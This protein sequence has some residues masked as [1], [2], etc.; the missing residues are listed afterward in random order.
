LGINALNKLIDVLRGENGCPWDKK[1]TPRS[2][3]VYL[4]E[5]IYELLEAIESG[6]TDDICE[7]LGDVLFHILFIAKL[8]QEMGS[9]NIEDA[10]SVNKEKM[11]RRHPHVFGDS[12]V[13]RPDDLRKQWH[14]IKMNEKTHSEN[15]SI[16]DSIP[17]GLPALRRAYRISE[18]AARVGFDWD[19]ISDVMQKVEEECSE[20]K[21][22]LN[23]SSE[24]QESLAIE[25]GDVIFTLVNVARFAR[26]HP[27]NA[28]TD[29][30]KKFENRFKYIEKVILKSGRK[31]ESVSQGEMNELWE[32]AKRKG[33][34]SAT[35]N[36]MGA[37]V[38]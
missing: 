32:E 2:M 28:L 26:I 14:Q 11:I 10:A 29:S 20:L 27:E 23:E 17:S 31:I 36:I 5:E 19:N 33:I 24:N 25:I 18:R 16:L 9:F 15:K 22:E 38:H 6:N 3:S 8:F 30:I 21:T 13:S 4:V 34:G 37:S 1:Q 35:K 7:E 12:K